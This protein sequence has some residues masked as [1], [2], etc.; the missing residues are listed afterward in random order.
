MKKFVTIHQPQYFPYLPTFQKILLGDIFI[1]LDDV[2]FSQGAWHS[3]TILK[4]K[5][6]EIISLTIPVLKESVNILDKKIANNKW[7]IRHLK[8][9]ESV[10]RRSKYFSDFFSLFEEI[11]NQK[12][13]YLVDY[14]STSITEIL[15]K[16]DY[17]EEN[18]F[19][20][21]ELGIDKKN[22][23][24]NTFLIEIIKRFNGTAYIS[25]QGAKNYIDEKFFEK[26]NIEL[27]YYA[28]KIEYLQFG[29]TY[30]EGLS[31][32][33]SICHLGYE[34]LSNLIKNK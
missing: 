8:T 10:Y 20:Q 15:K 33:D 4:N 12:S 18:I 31:V 9:I 24:K 16:L 19:K 25:G 23:S 26:N 30:H 34:R 17:K 7:K 11:L 1:S 28:N 21:S 32:I 13:L 29:E 27:I 2:K 14:T 22:Y 6:D 3:R 5:K